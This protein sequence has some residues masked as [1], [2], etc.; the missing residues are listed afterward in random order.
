LTR[1]AN[2]SARS[3]QVSPDEDLHGGDTNHLSPAEETRLQEAEAA[4]RD[5]GS[6]FIAF[7]QTEKLTLLALRWLGYDPA[8]VGSNFIGL[9]NLIGQ[10]GSHRAHYREQVAKSLRFSG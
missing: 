1:C 4:L 8:T 7:A 9:S 3:K 10:Y 5:C 2:V 6:K